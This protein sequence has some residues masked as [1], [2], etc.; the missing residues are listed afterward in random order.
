MPLHHTLNYRKS[1]FVS[2]SFFSRKIMEFYYF[3]SVYFIRGLLIILKKDLKNKNQP[4]KFIVQNFLMVNVCIL[5]PLA[6]TYDS[7][8]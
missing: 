2:F 8:L 1:L 6:K 7:L 5:V 4:G 3:K